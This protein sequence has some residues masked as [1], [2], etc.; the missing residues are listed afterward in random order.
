VVFQFLDFWRGLWYQYASCLLLPASGDAKSSARRPK[1]KTET[2]GLCT[3]PHRFGAR[4]FSLHDGQHN[5][6]ALKRRLEWSQHLEKCFACL[7]WA[8]PL[9]G[10]LRTLI[11][12]SKLVALV[13][14]E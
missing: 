9:R 1:P 3:R 10:M 12:F 8:A 4:L 13:L 2:D 11:I 7:E 5:Q 14:P 6:P